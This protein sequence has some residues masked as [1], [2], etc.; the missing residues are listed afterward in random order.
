[1]STDIKEL[2]SLLHERIEYVDDEELLRTV[3]AILDQNNRSVSEPRLTEYQVKRIEK[4][5]ES[6]RK[7][8]TLTNEQAD[9]LV[10][11]WLNE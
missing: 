7:G 8:E 2:K 5:K 1:M 6:I 10:D 11:R 3:K 4:A 9:E